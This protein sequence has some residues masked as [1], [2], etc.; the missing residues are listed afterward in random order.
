MLHHPEGCKRV[1]STILV[2]PVTFLL[3]DPMVATN[4][5]YKEPRNTIDFLMH[6]FVARELFIANALSRHFNWSHNILFVEDLSAVD[7]NDRNAYSPTKGSATSTSTNE[8]NKNHH[9][10]ID[11]DNA[12]VD[13]NENVSSLPV[14]H[15]VRILTLLFQ[16]F[17]ILIASIIIMGFHFIPYLYRLF[18]LREIL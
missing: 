13:S 16:L 6:F 10:S 14:R 18:S 15:T 9:P 7:P 1:S 2:D 8:N 12:S 11:N 17:L 5:V 4:V 3:C